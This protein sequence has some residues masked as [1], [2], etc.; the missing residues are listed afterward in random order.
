M[1][2]LLRGGARQGARLVLQQVRPAGGAATPH[3][4]G[5]ALVLGRTLAASRR[6]QR[7][8]KRAA[9]ASKCPGVPRRSEVPIQ[10]RYGSF[11]PSR[12]PPLLPRSSFCMEARGWKPTGIAIRKA[13]AEGFPS[14]AHQV[15]VSGHLPKDVCPCRVEEKC[16]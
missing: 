5:L 10:T 1:P 13:L 4:E 15:Q 8:G 16:Q 11:S 7:L 3:P 6:N 12:P 14:V 9:R 2:P